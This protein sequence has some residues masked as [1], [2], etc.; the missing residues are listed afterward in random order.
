MAGRAKAD[1]ER[2]L[3]CHG[4]AGAGQGFSQGD[5]GK[6]AR[7]DGLPAS[8][9]VKQVADYRSGA[10]RHDF[11]A[12][13]ARTLDQADLLDIAAYFAAQPRRASAATPADAAVRQLVEQGDARRGL[14]ACASC[15]AGGADAPLLAGQG[16]RYLA[17]Q[18]HQWRSG[19]RTNSPGG[20]M[21]RQAAALS[22]ADIAAL[23]RYLS[24]L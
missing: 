21:N 22:D 3:E 24:S 23:A 17:D 19:A 14:L 8:Y 1:A 16:E 15:H 18:L 7:L 20:V 13:M 6:Y 12:M 11:M 2:C 5:D 10:R 4:P 9:L